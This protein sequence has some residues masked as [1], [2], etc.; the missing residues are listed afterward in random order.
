MGWCQC[1]VC[2]GDLVFAVFCDVVLVYRG[3]MVGFGIE[4]R[5]GV[6]CRRWWP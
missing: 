6:F 4:V 3:V 1:V 5:R 2:C